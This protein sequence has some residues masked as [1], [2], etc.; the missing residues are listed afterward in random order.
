[1]VHIIIPSCKPIH[2]CEKLIE[3]LHASCVIVESIIHTGFKVSASTNRNYGLNRSSAEYVIMV[4]DDM[5]GFYTGWDADLVDALK[6]N[7]AVAVS[8]RLVNADGSTGEMMGLSI[9]ADG[10]VFIV[11]EKVLPTACICFKNDGTRFDEVFIGSGW[12]DTDFCKQLELRYPDK[13][14]CIANAIKLVHNNEM[15]NQNGKYWVYNKQ[16][17]ML[18]WGAVI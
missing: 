4:D 10:D 12:E 9:P 15:K 8:P 16:Y 18:K 7:G 5:T 11:K 1:M 13:P 3:E 2:E 14:F 6:S 17:F